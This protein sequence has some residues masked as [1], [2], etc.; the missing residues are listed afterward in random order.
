MSS[1]PT[2]MPPSSRYSGIGGRTREKSAPSRRPSNGFGTMARPNTA[3]AR[4]VAAIIRMPAARHELHVG[5]RL[6]IVDRLRPGLPG[7]RRARRA[8]RRPGSARRGSARPPRRCRRSR[9]PC[10]DGCPGSTAC[11]PRSRRCRRPAPTSRTAARRGLRA[12]RSAPPSFRPVRRRRR[13]DRL[14]GGMPFGGQRVSFDRRMTLRYAIC[15]P[16]AARRNFRYGESGWEATVTSRFPAT[17]TS[18][19]RVGNVGGIDET[20]ARLSRSRG[21]A[22]VGSRPCR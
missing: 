1:L 16:F 6:E 8:A 7:R 10:S 20:R 11:R 5:A 15:K 12:T 9:P 17:R 14:R 22:D 21:I 4:Q 3:G 2:I 18:A 19:G 13:A